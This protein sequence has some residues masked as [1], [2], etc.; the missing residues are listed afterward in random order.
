MIEHTLTFDIETIPTSRKLKGS[1][2][3]GC[4]EA[5]ISQMKR[6][7]PNNDYSLSDLRKV[8]N[9][10]MSV[11]PYFGEIVA[12][13]LYRSWESSSE[14]TVLTG[15]EKDILTDFWNIL[16]KFKKG[17]F[18]SF[19]GLSFDVPFILKRSMFH[20]IEPTNNNFL[21][22]KRYSKWPHFDVKLILS[23]YDKYARGTLDLVCNFLNIKS[24]KEGKIKAENVYSAYLKGDIGNIAK[25]CLRDVKATFE[26]YQ[27]LKKYIFTPYKNKY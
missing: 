13:A 21:D 11:T 9:L 3:Q 27:I 22:L 20:G 26:V 24:P 8:R 7:F 5:I 2:K 10:I 23:D 15:N 14:E 6:N 19:N 4:K 16:E 1:L 12:I 17:T 25:Y 18:V